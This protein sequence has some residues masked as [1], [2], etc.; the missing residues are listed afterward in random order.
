M[1]AVTKLQF[2]DGD[3]NNGNFDIEAV[4]IRP[5]SNGYVVTIIDEEEENE[6]VYTDKQEMMLDVAKYL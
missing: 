2:K 1:S 6:Y 3:D 5:V 4:R